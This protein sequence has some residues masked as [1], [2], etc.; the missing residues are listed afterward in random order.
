LG[1]ICSMAALQRDYPP[2]PRKTTLSNPKIPVN[3][4]TRQ[5][6]ARVSMSAHADA[7]V[8]IGLILTASRDLR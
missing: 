4:R 7:L 5:C 8:P 3:K 2:S 1:L 6:C